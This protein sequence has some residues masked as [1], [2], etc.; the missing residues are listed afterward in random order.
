MQQTQQKTEASEAVPPFKLL[1]FQ[2]VGEVGLEPTK[3]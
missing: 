1:T 2:V 3:A